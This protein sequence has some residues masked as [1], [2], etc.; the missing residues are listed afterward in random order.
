MR[1]K[2]KERTGLISYSLPFIPPVGR[3]GKETYAEGRNEKGKK[4]DKPFVL[5]PPLPLG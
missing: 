4:A 3:K 5:L 1:E 2:K